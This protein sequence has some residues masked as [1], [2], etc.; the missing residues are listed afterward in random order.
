[1]KKAFTWLDN[2]NIQYEFH[3]YKKSG[4]DEDIVK[5]ALQQHGWEQVINKR[6]TTWRAL[7]EEQKSSMSDEN[8]IMAARE[9]PSILKRPILAMNGQIWL[10]FS[11]ETYSSIAF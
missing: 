9:N 8:A 4:I 11:P 10:G 1:M 7:S 3:D 6:G 5:K 2:N